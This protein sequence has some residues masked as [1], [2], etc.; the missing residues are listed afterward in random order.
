[1]RGSGCFFDF[2]ERSG[3]INALIA[4]VAQLSARRLTSVRRHFLSSLSP[5][6]PASA[7]PVFPLSL[8]DGRILSTIFF[9]LCWPAAL[10]SASDVERYLWDAPSPYYLAPLCFSGICP[11]SFQFFLRPTVTIFMW[12]GAAPLSDHRHRD[13]F[14]FRDCL[15]QSAPLTQPEPDH[16]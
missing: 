9:I 13:D 4:P 2:G 16:P 15:R 7:S 5:P 12:L 14:V 11:Y 1:M 8:G 10:I 3:A 6:A